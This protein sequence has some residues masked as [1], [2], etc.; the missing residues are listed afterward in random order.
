MHGHTNGDV[1]HGRAHHLACIVLRV[2]L[3]SGALVSREDCTPHREC[4][5]ILRRLV[6]RAGCKERLERGTLFDL[7][8]V[9]L[10]G[11][12]K[13]AALG[14]TRRHCALRLS[15][16]QS[17]HLVLD[18]CRAGHQQLWPVHILASDIN[19]WEKEHEQLGTLV[20]YFCFLSKPAA[21]HIF[22]TADDAYYME[23]QGSIYQYADLH[24]WHAGSNVGLAPKFLL[25]FTGYK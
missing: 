18:Q 3:R 14:E 13:R 19:P 1:R 7:R 16:Q 8:R 11:E 10:F 2:A 9:V 5:L 15:V 25:T 21:G 12:T 24:S 23:Q 17:L 20:R 22:V 4:N 6:V